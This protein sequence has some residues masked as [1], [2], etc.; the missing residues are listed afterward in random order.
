MRPLGREPGAHLLEK[1]ELVPELDV[2][3]RVGHVE[4]AD[5]NSPMRT[6]PLGREPGAH[7]LEK[8]ELVPRT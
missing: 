8:V 1:V 7:L 4:I 6:R 5:E 2:R 3:D